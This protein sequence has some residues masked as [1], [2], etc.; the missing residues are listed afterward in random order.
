MRFDP[1]YPNYRLWAN[2][3]G[4]LYYDAVPDQVALK[5]KTNAYQTHER[6]GRCFCRVGADARAL[7]RE[8]DGAISELLLD[9]GVTLPSCYAELLVMRSWL[10]IQFHSVV[11]VDD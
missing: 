4:R 7:E 11:N 2:A 9:C 10:V 3:C 5:P 1:N 8:L 6:P